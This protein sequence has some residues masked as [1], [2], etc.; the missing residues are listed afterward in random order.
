MEPIWAKSQQSRTLAEHTNDVRHAFTTLFGAEKEPSTFG[1]RW[2][3]FFG[4]S[5]FSLFWRSTDAAVIFHD[6][7]K[8]NDGFQRAV[9]HGEPQDIRHEHLSGLFLGLESVANWTAHRKDIDWDV[10]LGAVISHHLKCGEFDQTS[11]DPYAFGCRHSTSKRHQFRV[12]WNTPEC[13]ELWQIALTLG[14]PPTRPE[15]PPPLWRFD[16]SENTFN[17]TEHAAN[18]VDGRLCKFERVLRDKPANQERR[19]LMWA[20][21]SALIISD[22]VG[23]AQSRMGRS[24]DDFVRSTLTELPHFTKNE[25][26]SEIIDKR[27]NQLL[28]MGRWDTTKGVNGWSEFQIECEQLPSRALL[29]APC[30]SG[31]TLAAWRWIAQQCESP[32]QR[33]LFLYPTR[34]TA[35]EGFRDYVSWAPESDAGLIHGT[36]EYELDGMFDNP[37]EEFADPRAGK[38]FQT[39][40]RLYSLGFWS[41]RVVSA[42]VD[43]FLG[44][45]Q[46]QYQ[47]LLML[48][49]LSNSVI[50]IDEV[51]SYDRGM[52]SALLDLLKSF[53]VPVL[54]MT[55]SLPRRRRELLQQH[56]LLL[57]NFKGGELQAIAQAPR[58]QISWVVRDNAIKAI[59]QALSE[60]RKVLWV[61]NQVRRAQEALQELSCTERAHGLSFQIEGMTVSVHCYHSRFRLNDRKAR[62]RETVSAFQGTN[63]DSPRGAVLAITTQVCEMSLDLD[64]D[65]L[66]TELAPITSL[67]QR[68]GRCNRVPT[69]R[70]TGGQVL[71]YPSPDGSNLPYDETSLN[72]AEQFIQALIQRQTE[73]YQLRVNQEDLEEALE[74]PGDELPTK[75]R[76]QFLESGPYAD[77]Q[78]ET[79]RDLDEF[80]T[81][82][83]LSSDLPEFFRLR[84]AGQPT[85]G[86][87]LPVPRKQASRSTDPRFPKYLSIAPGEYYSPLRGL[88]E[89]PIRLI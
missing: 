24:L 40:S 56:G 70:V 41:K 31:K 61:V 48:P 16:K 46:Y 75:K 42:T 21:R 77:G 72:S 89:N 66:V 17:L 8:A 23:S 81:P 63:S 4:I 36:A 1:T 3:Q 65:L 88:C 58:Y 20:V 2:Q 49:L 11:Q 84:S 13:E 53:Q 54:C 9:L 6:W 12:L 55:A 39:D 83:V 69:P 57:S 14:L 71:I 82:G 10:V 18:L 7:G 26:W 37:A 25:V 59:R 45:M 38:T 32:T 34:G 15:L 87:I 86:L 29:V 78:E 35:T 19:H 74:T 85:D 22:A 51:H 60:G 80:T 73:S 43:Q 47:S 27:V 5:D 33:V 44:Y 30:G 68:M 79:L 64:A 76:C 28:A 52:F 67:I 62:H 50:V